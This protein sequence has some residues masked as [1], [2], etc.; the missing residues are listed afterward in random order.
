MGQA[1]LDRQTFLKGTAA[2]AGLL[3][4]GVPSLISGRSDA[5][6]TI[7][8]GIS[9]EMTGVYADVARSE[10]NGMQM[11]L[12]A[13]N[14]RGGVLGR[15]VELIIQDNANNPGT[16]VQKARELI[17][18]DK[19][20]ALVGTVNSANSI[21]TSGVAFENKIPFLDSG[22]HADAVTAEKCHWTSFRTCHTTWMETHATGYAIGKKFGKKWYFIAPDYAFGH[23]LVDGYNAVAKQIGATIVGIDF[24]PLGTPDF[25]AYL[26]KVLNAKPDCLILMTGG[27]DFTNAIKQANSMGLLGRIP[28]AGPQ[29]EMETFWSLPKEARVGYWGMEWYYNSPKVHGSNPA[30]SQF[31]KEYRSLYKRPPTARSVFGYVSL[32]RM[33]NAIDTAKSTDPVKICRAIPG[34][35]FTALWNSASHYSEV[36]HQ[37]MWPM[38]F[39]EIK[40]SSPNGDEYDLFDVTDEQPANAIAQSDAEL[41]KICSLGWP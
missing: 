30:V 14:K 32:E 29:G 37:L 27:D 3:T 15:K 40:A 38:W 10:V 6:D 28:I 39:G 13:Q 31:V 16:A 5:A 25:S 11:A 9:E 1:D 23:A 22:G 26:T 33:M 8:I 4:I 12:D 19:V 18:S 7:K 36:S 35:N 34:Q 41:S 2:A 24:T 21:A 20:V 17:Q